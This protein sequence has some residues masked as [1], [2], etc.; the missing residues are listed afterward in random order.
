MIV[1][2]IV[3]LLLPSVELL[4]T[5]QSDIENI[6]DIRSIDLHPNGQTLAI[7]GRYGSHPE[8]RVNQK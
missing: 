4:T 2:L 3:L 7:G 1:I 5:A 6:T 8:F